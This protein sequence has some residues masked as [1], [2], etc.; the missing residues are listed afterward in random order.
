M[1]PCPPPPTDFIVSGLCHALPEQPAGPAKALE[2]VT[3]ARQMLAPYVEA[4]RWA[5]LLPQQPPATP[6]QARGGPLLLR[7]AKSLAL[8]ARRLR[9][10][11]SLHSCEALCTDLERLA[12][13]C[14]AAS[15]R[16]RAPDGPGDEGRA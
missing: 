6:Q 16:Q 12:A 8:A 3:L 2:F 9:E 1:P 11:P 14:L 15:E 10:T 5:N 7:A 4:L 13:E